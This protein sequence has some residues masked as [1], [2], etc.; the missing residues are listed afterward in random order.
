MKKRKAKKS[1]HSFFTF[2]WVVFYAI[3]LFFCVGLISLYRYY[4]FVLKPVNVNN[5]EIVKIKVSEED[6]MK[7]ILQKLKQNNLI[8]DRTLAYIYAKQNKLTNYYAGVYDLSQSMSLNEILTTINTLDAA[9]EEGISV[10][11]IE[12]DWAKDIAKKIAKAVPA[13][14]DEEL[15]NLW[16]NQEWIRSLMS[17]YPFLSEDMF[18]S[19]VRCYLEG[20]LTPQTYHFSEKQTAKEITEQILD[21]TLAVYNKFKPDFAASS[22]SVHDIYTLASIV[23]YEGGSDEEVLKNIAGVFYNRLNVNMKL[24]SSVTVCYAIDFDKNVDDWQSC[25]VLTDFDSPYNTYLYEGLPPG[26]IQNAGEAA[27]TAVL[28]PASHNYYFFVADVY[29]DGKVYFSS[30]AEEHAALVQKYLS[31]KE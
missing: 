1:F 30:T 13:V 21:Q 11:I 7:S 16:N 25:E 3:L 15:M 23:Q 28:H 29:G 22:L 17:K 8:Q 26:P 18:Q 4:R 14:S 31:G 10:T 2:G 5:A 27:L 19:G 24:Q 6:T 20:Y 12:G 9:K